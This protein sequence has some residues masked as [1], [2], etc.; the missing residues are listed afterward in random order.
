MAFAEE[1]YR[2]TVRQ[3][4]F[5]VEYSF[6]IAWPV[7]PTCSSLRR[8]IAVAVPFVVAC[9]QLVGSVH[10]RCPLG[11]QSG[12][13]HRHHSHFR[14]QARVRSGM[15]SVCV[16]VSDLQCRVECNGIPE[17]NSCPRAS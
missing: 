10:V 16:L 17:S 4:D 11:N 6:D 8:M 2:D 1:A 9:L 14:L 5:A 7:Q 15:P 13:R 12:T 3:L